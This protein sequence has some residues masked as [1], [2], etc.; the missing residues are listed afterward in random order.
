MAKKI[1]GKGEGTIHKRPNGTWRAQ[2]TLQGRRLSKTTKTHREAH[3]WLREIKN[4][5][6]DGLTYNSTKLTLEQYLDSWLISTKSSIRLSTWLQYETW[7]RRYIKPH[8]GK[9]KVN[10]LRP[11]QIQTFYN[12]LLATGVG[13]WTIRK[14]HSVLHNA[15]AGAIDDEILTRNPATKRKIPKE[16]FKKMNILNDSQV[17]QLLITVKDTQWEAL[18]HLAVSSGMRQMELLGL[19][20]NDLDWVNQ[21]IRVER[22]LVRSNDKCI[23]YAPPKTHYGKRTI[24]LGAKVI[25]V[26]RSH[27]LRQH[28]NRQ[29]AGD[30]WVEN[31][32]IFT[33]RYGGKIHFRNLLR[34]FK[35][36]LRKA[37]LPE[38]RFHDL[39]HT[40]AS[41]ML[42][43]GIPVIVV[44]SRLGHAKPSITQNVYGHLIPSMHSGV[45]DMIDDLITPIELPSSAPNCTR[46]APDLAQ[47]PKTEEQHPNI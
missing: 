16:P 20:W 17:S 45:G 35:N 15:L 44:S 26:L 47:E 5:I 6:D 28:K 8:L 10:E 19:C 31:G 29:H 21:T 37:G 3:Q 1:R 14:V 30:R 27:Y 22:Q 46:S 43:H 34:D 4:Q 38:I 39:R 23:Q 40:A 24:E 42:N 2:I 33:T 9:I 12:H 13:K 25:D 32:L 36:V 18:L 41:L 11:D 7:I